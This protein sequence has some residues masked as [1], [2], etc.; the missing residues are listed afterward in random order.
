MMVLE[1]MATA[2]T[3]RLSLGGKPNANITGN[4]IQELDA[5]KRLVFEW[6]TFDHIAIT[7]TFADMTQANFDYAHINAVT[8]DRQGLFEQRLF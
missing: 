5:D 1:N 3:M 6:H 4:V 7:N 2:P 8:I